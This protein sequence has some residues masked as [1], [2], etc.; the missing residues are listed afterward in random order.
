MIR[1]VTAIVMT[2]NHLI[3]IPTPVIAISS[4]TG[5]QR[6]TDIHGDVVVAVVWVFLPSCP[7]LVLR[8][9]AMTSNAARGLFSPSHARTSAHIL[10]WVARGRP[11]GL[12]IMTMGE[13]RGEGRRL[14]GTA[15]LLILLLVA[16]VFDDAVLVVAVRV[17]NDDA[18]TMATRIDSAALAVAWGKRTTSLLSPAAA[19][20]AVAVAVAV[21]IP[22]TSPP[23]VNVVVASRG[24]LQGGPRPE[25][26]DQVLVGGKEGNN[27]GAAGASADLRAASVRHGLRPIAYAG[28]KEAIRMLADAGRPSTPRAAIPRPSSGPGFAAPPNPASPMNDTNAPAGDR[29]HV[30]DRRLHLGASEVAEP[31]TA[32]GCNA[33]GAAK[34]A[35][36]RRN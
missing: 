20:A 21:R 3:T 8:V 13:R 9:I 12:P 7:R 17:D 35:R 26:P 5:V 32:P 10:S 30:G 23:G 4:T 29:P 1:A 33:P 2:I 15:I 28:E 14:G 16:K 24:G 19:V 11:A 6:A 31:G 36:D 34:K 18:A 22:T 27:A 25:V